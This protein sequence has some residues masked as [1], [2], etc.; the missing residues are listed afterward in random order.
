MQ[1]YTSADPLKVITNLNP[2]LLAEELDSKAPDGV[3]Q[4]RPNH[5]PNLLPFD[6]RF[7]I[8]TKA[9][10]ELTRLP[11][12]PVM[13]YQPYL[14]SHGDG[15][16]YGVTRDIAEADLISVLRATFPV[17]CARHLSQSETVKLLLPPK[18]HHIMLPSGILVSM[19]TLH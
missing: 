5:R 2:K 1:P 10:L 13:A 15:I 7:L 18:P 9:L 3:L 16:I 6:T 8:S 17:C 12:I 19:L 4:L 14:L 11:E